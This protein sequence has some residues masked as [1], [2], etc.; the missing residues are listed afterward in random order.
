MTSRRAWALIA[1]IIGAASGALEAQ[2]SPALFPITVNDTHGM[3]DRAG[4]V[5]IPAEYSEPVIVRDGLARVSKGTKVAY[6]DAAGHFV[7]APQDAAREPFAEG[8]TPA[9]GRDE[10]GKPAWGYIGRTGAFVISPR[11]ADAKPFSEGFAQVGVADQWGEVKYG[12]A[13]KAGKLVI[14]ARYGK[15]FPFSAGLAR[16]EVDKRLRVLDRTGADVT[17]SG[18]DFIGIAAEGLYRVWSG[19]M[20][21]YMDGSA[22]VVI[23]P[24]F[25][26]AREF[27]DGLA[28][29]WVAGKYG[30]VNR[31]GTVVIAPQW[32]VAD[33]F[34][35]GRA[36]VKVGEKYG[37]ID[38]TGAL[39]IPATLSHAMK[40]SEGLAAAKLDK[41][42]GYV[43]RAGTW[44]ISPRFLWVRP[45]PQGLAGVGEPGSRGTYIDPNGRVVWG[46]R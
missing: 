45:F 7:I 43:D 10:A 2:T 19:R 41:H 33:D 26:Q 18:I 16:V 37:Y 4:Q 29:V 32:Q 42:Y 31:Q 38:K 20:Q 23:A 13:D 28:A 5:V 24:Q 40:F 30:Y 46:N 17:P 6:L 9:V 3:I 35:D 39:V 27:S 44:V 11:F 12:Y 14:P 21:G 36:A 1:L 22:K 34:V 15:T 8:L 25:E